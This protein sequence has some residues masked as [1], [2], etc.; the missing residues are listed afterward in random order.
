MGGKE[1][2]DDDDDDDDPTISRSSGSTLLDCHRLNNFPPDA[3][4]KPSCLL[5]YFFSCLSF[6]FFSSSSANFI[7]ISLNQRFPISIIKRHF[8]DYSHIL[9]L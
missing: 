4:L 3:S 7:A 9:I 5:S 6:C 2:M 8:V 1:G